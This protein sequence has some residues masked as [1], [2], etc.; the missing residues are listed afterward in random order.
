MTRITAV[1]VLALFAVASLTPAAEFP[2]KQVN[3]T[4]SEAMSTPGGNGTLSQLLTTKPE[5]VKKEPKAVSKYVLYGTIQVDAD[6]QMVYRVDE[7]K[8]TEKGYDTLILDLNRNGDLT[9]DPVGKRVGEPPKQDASF[10][11]AQFGPIEVSADQTQG[12]WRPSVFGEMYL[13]DRSALKRGGQMSY[14][15]Y[16]RVRPCSYLEATV[17]LNGVKQKI[18]FVD[19][20]CNMKIGDSGVFQSMTSGSEIYWN[21]PYGDA[22]LRDLDGSGKFEADTVNREMEYLASLMYFGSDPYKVTLSEDYKT[23]R[24]DP[25]D[26]PMGEM[27]LAKDQ[28]VAAL[29]MGRELEKGEW[30]AVSPDPLADKIRM[31]VGKYRMYVCVVSA[32]DENDATVS[33]MGMNRK[34]AGFVE[35]KE[36]ETAGLTC[37]APIDLRVQA[38]KQSNSGGILGSLIG[39]APTSQININVEVAGAGGEVYSTFMKIAKEGYT[40][41]S[42]PKFKVLDA[43]GKEIASGQLEY[44]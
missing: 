42:P 41:P 32:K 3:L 34:A 7:S 19:G 13:Y 31:P 28:K 35:I 25:F 9:D 6:N 14:A 44:G 10:E 40:Q 23:V 8:G 21:L 30:E 22:V 12:Q 36:G 37:G 15:G 5:A 39:T 16:L 2:L 1:I 27:A 33:A 11:N 17:D 43:E 26:G 24:F 18:A 29:V 4:V 20:S 38:K